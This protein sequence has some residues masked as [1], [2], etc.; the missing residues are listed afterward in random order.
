MERRPWVGTWLIQSS[1]DLANH[2][3]DRKENPCRSVILSSV[4]SL[5]AMAM[6]ASIGEVLE[7]SRLARAAFLQWS[8]PG[9]WCRRHAVRRCGG[10][11]IPS[12]NA[13]RE[14]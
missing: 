14:L 12:D 8:M 9:L 2:G 4:R 11:R 6:P 7:R 1:Q 5:C 10:D 13:R 3:K